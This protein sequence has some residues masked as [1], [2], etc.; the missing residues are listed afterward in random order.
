MPAEP[1]F[2]EVIRM[3]VVISM[4]D[5]GCDAGCLRDLRLAAD[6]LGAVLIASARPGTDLRLEVVDDGTDAYVRMAV[7]LPSTGSPSG[8]TDLALLLLDATVDSYDIRSDGDELLGVLQ[9]ALDSE[10]AEAGSRRITDRRG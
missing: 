3:A 7:P 10:A 5:S 1:R 2:L 4:R 8:S 6:E 9:R